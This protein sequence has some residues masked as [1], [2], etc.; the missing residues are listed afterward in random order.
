MNEEE[1]KAI[2]KVKDV[3]EY[4]KEHRIVTIYDKQPLF[5]DTL[6]TVLNLIEKQQK[7]IEELQELSISVRAV[8]QID[9]M[10][11]EIEKLKKQLD[12]DNECEIALNNRI[13]DLENA[14]KK[15]EDKIKAK[16]EEIKQ[17]KDLAR[18]RIQEKIVIADSDS[19]NYGRKE[20]HEKDIEVLQSLLEKE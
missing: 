17:Y 10:Q 20:A 13:M 1:K 18:D 8:N 5:R 19:L 4:D 9:K 3:I 6:Q 12:L 2:A 7:E 14:D 15:W 11:K 16:I